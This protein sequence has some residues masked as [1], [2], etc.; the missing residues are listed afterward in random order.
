LIKSKVLAWGLLV[1][2]ITALM[3]VGGCAQLSNEASPAPGTSSTGFDWTFLII[4][5]VIIVIFYFFM[6]RPQSNR[7]KQQQKLLDEL[8]SGDQVITTSG[9]YGEIES[10][11]QDSIVLKIESGAK[12]RFARQ[13][14]AGKRPE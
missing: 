4:I 3:F 9:I 13:S 11:D 10:L 6:I 8:K 14:I 2:L 12:I 1:W 7:R 5:L